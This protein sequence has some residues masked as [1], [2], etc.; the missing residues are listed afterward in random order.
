MSLFSSIQLAGNALRASQIGL[1]VV[2]QNIANANTPGYI[3]EEVV[4]TPATTQ[5]VGKLLFGLGVDVEAVVQKVDK[6]LQE[7]LRNA[8]SDRASGQVQED[9][10]AQL[11][12]LLNELGDEDLSTTLGA[13][14]GSIQEILNAPESLATRHLAILRGQ[15]LA[16][17][18]RRLFSRTLEIRRDLDDRVKKAAD[19]INRLL[20]EIAALNVKIAKVE[21][22]STGNSDAVGLRDQRG[23]LLSD[24][25]ELI[26]IRVDEQT[27]GQT[28]V[29]LNGI[30]LVAE[31][32]YREV[33]IVEESD[34]GFALSEVVLADTEEPIGQ[35]GGRLAGLKIARDEIV[36]QFLDELDQFA[37]ALIYEFNRVFSG[38]QGLQGY[39]EVESL[40]AVEDAT[41]RLD[42]AGLPFAVQSGSFQVMVYDQQTGLTETTDI[43]IDLLDPQQGTTLEQLAAA[44]DA[45]EGVGAE[46][47][48]TRTLRIWAQSP[49]QQVAFAGDTSGVLAALG[50]NVFF[51][52]TG[53]GSIEVNPTVAQNPALFAASAGGV[54]ADTQ[55][56]VELG[57][58]LDRPLDSLQ[59]KT[60]ADA[61]EQMVSN[62]TQGSSAAR[63]VAE[64][65]RVFEETLLGQHLAISGV[66]LDEEAV[67]MLAFQRMFQAAAR[68]IATINELLDVLVNL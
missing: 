19:D 23:K 64:G 17:D 32:I 5:Q 22:G 67:K 2:G 30:Y 7:R 59:G 16:D 57:G 48:D 1:Q 68:F 62:V 43:S 63:A 20:K 52:G 41:V 34:E 27:E 53:A 26:D 65:Y 58:F 39:G 35:T 4:L 40:F 29:S 38:G 13:F 11:E 46:V 14:F 8:A 21:A 55:T 28:N 9:A 6:F 24:L 18:I 15:T 45:V 61:Y 36:G 33:K 56:A 54:G 50:I 31:G 49:T 25:A 60:I 3:R 47:T 10:Y 42:Q 66:S 12:A 51:G 37:A 44:L